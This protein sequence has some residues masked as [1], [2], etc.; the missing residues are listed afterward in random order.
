MAVGGNQTM[1]GVAVSVGGRGVSVGRGGRGVRAGRQALRLVQISR[2]HRNKI[3][4]L[5][6]TG[7]PA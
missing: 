2:L 1:V 7:L 4:V 5:I 6:C 3:G